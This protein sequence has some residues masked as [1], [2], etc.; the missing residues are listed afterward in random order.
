M[1]DEATVPVGRR[2]SMGSGVPLWALVFIAAFFVITCLSVW[3]FVAVSRPTAP[4]ATASA[5]FIVI[6]Q[7]AAL[8]PP[9]FDPLLATLGIPT[10]TTALAITPTIPVNV[11]PGFINLGSIVQ[12]A[13]TDGD[14]LK[15]RQQPS[16]NAEINYF[17]L[18]SEV[19][20]VDNGPTIADGYTWW[21][22]VDLVDGTKNG[23]AVENYLA[24][25]N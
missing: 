22:L 18:P 25:S 9:T 2:R 13:N 11:N 3:A 5:V 8:A 21:F 23:W 1:N 24:V 20:K 15:L 12:V 17:A 14:P 4:R 10:P 19:F 6:T 7:P 16:L